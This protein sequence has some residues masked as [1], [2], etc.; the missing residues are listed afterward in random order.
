M[1]RHKSKWV[2]FG[3]EAACGWKSG[4]RRTMGRRDTTSVSTGIEKNG[5]GKKKEKYSLNWK[6]DRRYKSMTGRP[7]SWAM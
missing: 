7:E 5:K 6:P 3:G 4:S 1:L 2:L